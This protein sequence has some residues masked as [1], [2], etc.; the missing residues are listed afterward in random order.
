MINR[1]C[2]D[3]DNVQLLGSAL[4]DLAPVHRGDYLCAAEL[5]RVDPC[6]EVFRQRRKDFSWFMTVRPVP[7][8]DLMPVDFLLLCRN[9]GSAL[10]LPRNPRRQ[11]RQKPGD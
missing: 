4:L 1:G 10:P 8:H 2:V 3:V 6:A 7:V 9:A 11:E 5:R